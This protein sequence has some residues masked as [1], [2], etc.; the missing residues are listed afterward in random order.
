MMKPVLLIVLLVLPSLASARSERQRQIPNGGAFSCDSC[1]G[2]TSLG[3]SDLTPFGADVHRNLSGGVVQWQNIWHLDSDGDGYSN[4]LELNDPS[5]TW[6]R[7][8]ADPVGPI[9][10]PGTPNEGI[11]GNGVL[12]SD[13]DCE[14]LGDATCQNLGLGAGQLECRN[15]KYYTYFCGVCG[16]GVLNP[17]KEDCDQDKFGTNT[18]AS[19][20][21]RSGEL[22]C[23]ASCKIDSTG[24]NDEAPAVCGDGFLSSGEQCD[25]DLF[26]SVDCAR[27]NFASGTLL[28]TPECKWDA[29]ECV[30]KDYTP[31]DRPD[32]DMGEPYD[33][34]TEDPLP[35]GGG[36][37]ESGCSSVGGGFLSLLLVP[38][39]ARRRR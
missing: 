37:D 22:S 1:H 26:G 4:G 33:P 29:S 23:T 20:G 16:D 5:G 36:T 28:C 2:K 3:V 39:F 24:C 7:G 14:E 18:C 12:E 17:L 27:L 25:G 19:F 34:G 21:F 8:Q 38:I 10:N 11:C 31:V 15:C 6:R 13:E 9:S 30:P 35:E 32:A